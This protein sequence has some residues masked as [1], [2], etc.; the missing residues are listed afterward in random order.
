MT[1]RIAQL[2]TL[3]QGERLARAR[4]VADLSQDQ[5]AAALG[6]DR[7]TIG[8]WERDQTPVTKAVLIAWAAVTDCPAQWLAGPPE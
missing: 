3:T 2:M 6:V 7:R 1:P 4:K 5:M 8:R